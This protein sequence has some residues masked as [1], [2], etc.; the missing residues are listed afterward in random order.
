[1]DSVFD[2]IWL[3]SLDWAH[4][5]GNNATGIL[6]EATCGVTDNFGVNVCRTVN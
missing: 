3:H 4:R 5:V 2:P 6:Q 1:M